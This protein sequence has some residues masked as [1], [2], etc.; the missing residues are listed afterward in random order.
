MREREVVVE[1][2]SAVVGA[3]HQGLAGLSDSLPNMCERYV[4]ARVHA[5]VR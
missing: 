3:A 4:C 2:A 5:C 1:A